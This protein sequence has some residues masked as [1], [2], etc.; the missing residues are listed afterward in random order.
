MFDYKRTYGLEDLSP[1]SMKHLAERIRDDPE[2]ASLYHWNT[3]AQSGPKPDSQGYDSLEDYCDL[4]S[5]I[6]EYYECQ[7]T[8]GMVDS[9]YG[10][11]P[12]F[13]S[14]NRIVDNYLIGNWIE[15]IHESDLN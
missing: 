14:P 15:V 13:F 9:K 11:K 8:K 7:K 6:Y 12:N 4:T 3:H 5:E 10:R 2:T 1:R